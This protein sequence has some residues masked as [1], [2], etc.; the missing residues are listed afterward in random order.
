[1]NINIVSE[2]NQQIKGNTVIVNQLLV[3]DLSNDVKDVAQKRSNLEL[4]QSDIKKSW[5]YGNSLSMVVEFSFKASDEDLKKARKIISM[6]LRRARLSLRI[7]GGKSETPLLHANAD[8]LGKNTNYYRWAPLD[9]SVFRATGLAAD[10]CNYPKFTDQQSLE[11]IQK[12]LIDINSLHPVFGPMMYGDQKWVNVAN[13]FRN[14]WQPK[15]LF[16]LSQGKLEI[17]NT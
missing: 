8:S 14:Y 7:N 1:M 3:A 9:K 10:G 16:A 5:I 17:P 15:L 11:I 12:N 4:M 6:Y 2:S 13:R